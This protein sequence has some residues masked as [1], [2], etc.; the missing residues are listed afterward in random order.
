MSPVAQLELWAN[1]Y[2][3]RFHTVNLLDHAGWIEHHAAGDYANDRIAENAAGNQREFPSLI[4]RDNRVAG[5]GASLIPHD[6]LVILGEDVYEFPLGFV[7]P[8]Q[9]NN[10]SA[11]HSSKI[12]AK[13]GWKTLKE[14]SACRSA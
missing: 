2:A 12:L 10:A 4:T 3:P 8:L 13:K 14:G 6:D 1:Q 7:A 9:T 11:G 5:V